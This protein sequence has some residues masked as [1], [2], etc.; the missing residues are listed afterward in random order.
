[1]TVTTSAILDNSVVTQYDADYILNFHMN[2]LW[3]K[4]MGDTQRRKVSPSGAGKKGKTV[5]LAVYE[6]LEPPTD[7]LTENLDVTPKTIDDTYVECTIYEE[8]DVIQ[9]SRWL[10]VVAYTD[11]MAAI[12]KALAK[13][14]ARRQDNI[15]RDA[16]V[17]AQQRT[18]YGGGGVSRVDLNTTD[19]K[20][21]FAKFQEAYGMAV[22]QGI[23][24]FEDRSEE[25]RVG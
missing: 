7:H 13:Q 16:I 6:D 1:M 12:A 2:E 5:Q 9:S 11:Y 17:F 24:P 21:T 15:V 19:D 25:R 10:S 18:I 4:I 22:T 20:L 8:G 23:P 14:H 3:A